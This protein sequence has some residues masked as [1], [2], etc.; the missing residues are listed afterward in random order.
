MPGFLV[1]SNSKLLAG[2]G[3]VMLVLMVLI[4]YASPQT[5]QR[6][7]TTP[8]TYATDSGGALAAFRLLKDLHRNVTRFEQSPLELPA[9]SSNAMLIIANPIQEPSESEQVALRQFVENGGRL[10]LPVRTLEISFPARTW[11]RLE[12]A[13][14]RSCSGPTS[15]ASSRAARRKSR[16]SARPNG[17]A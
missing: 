5:A 1:S 9:D 10:L 4:S 11:W 17:R 12:R 13:T 16:W 8:S 15:R 14:R 6:G 2:A 3:A 7:S